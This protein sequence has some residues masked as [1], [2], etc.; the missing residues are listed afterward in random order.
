MSALS[1]IIFAD[2]RFGATILIDT[3]LILLVVNLSDNP[4]A[5]N[6]NLQTLLS[7]VAFLHRALSLSVTLRNKRLNITLAR[8]L[9]KVPKPATIFWAP[10]IGF[11]VC[12]VFVKKV[13][14]HYALVAVSIAMA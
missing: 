11:G 14:P 9:C 13:K 4:S 1:I 2:S 5:G 6:A 10:P 7:H 3:V 12:I 8:I